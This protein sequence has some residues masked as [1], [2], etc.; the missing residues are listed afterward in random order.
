MSSRGNLTRGRS[1]L[2]LMAKRVDVVATLSSLPH[3]QAQILYFWMDSGVM[4][5]MQ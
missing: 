3:A 1:L 5:I 4:V 2:R